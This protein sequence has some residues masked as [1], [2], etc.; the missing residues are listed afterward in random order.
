MLQLT[1]KEI[2]PLLS[3]SARVSICRQETSE[4]ENY[5]FL[6]WVPEKYDDL[7]VYGIGLITGTEFYGNEKSLYC[8]YESKEDLANKQTEKRNKLYFVDAL[9]ILLSETPRVE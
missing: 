9:E 8:T 3:R 4:Y 2:R 6:A 7:Y 1:F 5:L